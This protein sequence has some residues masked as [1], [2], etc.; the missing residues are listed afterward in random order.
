MNQ[1]ILNSNANRLELKQTFSTPF[2]QVW[3]YQYKYFLSPAIKGQLHPLPQI[4]LPDLPFLHLHTLVDGESIVGKW[5]PHSHLCK[6]LTG[7]WSSPETINLSHSAPVLCLFDGS[8]QNVLTVSV[9]EVSKDI[10]LLA[11]VHEETGKINL[12]IILQ[13]SESPSSGSFT[14]RFD[15]RKLPFYAVLQDVVSWWDKILPDK[16]MDIPSRARFPMYSTW[17]SYHQNMHAD[18][19]IAE[20]QKASR[21]GM[22]TV[23]I[24]DGWQTSDNNR[25]YGFCGDWNPEPGKFPDFSRHIQEIHDL[26]MKCILW[27]SVPFVGEYSAIWNKFKHMLLHYDPILHAGILDPRYP[28]VRQYLVSVY[29]NAYAKWNLDGFKLDFIDSFRIYSDTPAWNKEMDFHEIQ[30]AVYSLMLEISQTLAIKNPELL[31]EFRQQYIGPQMRRFGNI[32][33]VSDCPLSRVCNRTGITD[34]RLLSGNTAVHSDMIMWAPNESPENVG[35]L[36]INCIFAALQISVKLGEITPKQLNVLRHYLDFSIKY[37][38]VLLSGAFSVRNPLAQYPAVSS[39]KRGIFIQAVYD[40]RQ[41]VEF[42]NT[43]VTLY[44]LL[45]GTTGTSIGII[46]PDPQ[47]GTLTVFNCSGE[48][49]TYKKNISFTEIIQISI[50]SGGALKFEPLI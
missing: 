22:K 16:P 19:M 13:F 36:L 7:D 6:Q 12:H 18:E 15:Y 21:L 45:N 39:S 47:Q 17:Y 2:E 33:R 29:L 30:D 35:V 27:Y 1:K 31:I 44:W 37:Q 24:D 34:L 23:I 25:G 4:C 11:G 3:E 41:I 40:S 50:P 46:F 26:G 32:F 20:Y 38:D 43:N 8:D 28:Q 9:S 42:P 10:Q 48:I 5:Q 49:V 14:V